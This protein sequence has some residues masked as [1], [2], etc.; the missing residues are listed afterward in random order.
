MV[1]EKTGGNT[2]VTHITKPLK[3]NVIKLIKIAVVTVPKRSKS[4][5]PSFLMVRT[6]VRREAYNDPEYR[7]R[8]DE[9]K[10]VHECAQILTEF[11][12]QRGY[13]VGYLRTRR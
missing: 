2:E 11:C 3:P 9:A 8:L 4:A 6:E 5:T 12:H 10:S 7:R 13:S 1:N